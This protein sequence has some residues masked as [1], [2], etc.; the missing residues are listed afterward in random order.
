MEAFL[1]RREEEV[2]GQRF[3]LKQARRKL[4]TSLLFTSFDEGLVTW[5][6]LA[7]EVLA[8]EVPIWAVRSQPHLYH[9]EREEWI[10]VV[11]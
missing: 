3:T 1:I 11:S 9:H 7:T 5:P 8:D 4:H 2:Q 6:Q 10:L